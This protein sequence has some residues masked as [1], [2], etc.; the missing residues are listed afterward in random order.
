MPTMIDEAF[1]E[2]LTLEDQLRI[3]FTQRIEKPPAIISISTDEIDIP[4]FTL[5]NFSIIT[6]KAKSRKSFFTSAL[7]AA[8]IQGTCN[9]DNIVSNPGKEN[10]Y[11]IF[12]DTE[13]SSYHSQR[14]GFS[15]I[16]QISETLRKRYLHFK[17][18]ELTNKEKLQFIERV[19]EKYKGKI[20]LVVI[21]GIKDL[22]SNGI[23]DEAE[24]I[25]LVSKIMKW[26][27]VYNIHIVGVL[28]QN[29]NDKNVRGHIGTEAVN[30]AETTLSIEKVETEPQISIVKPEYTR[31]LEFDSFYFKLENFLPTLAYYEPRNIKTDEKIKTVISEIM[32]KDQLY[33]YT[34]LTNSYSEKSGMSIQTARRALKRASQ[35]NYIVKYNTFYKLNYQIYSH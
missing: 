15:V 10:H 35:L 24:S 14:L 30:K 16:K 34:D 33:S 29:K 13:M 26:T 28:H 3:D 25:D 21:D 8:S 2:L 19:L 31:E 11:S 23:N 20:A 1:K 22:L 5:G 7:L 18:R 17:L 27:S 9:L 12:F 32:V 6:G 4:M